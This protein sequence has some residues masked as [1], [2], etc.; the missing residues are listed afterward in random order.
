M[1]LSDRQ[2]K[3][4]YANGTIVIDPFEEKFVQPAS[5]DLRVGNQGITTSDKKVVDL[6]INK[7]IVIKPADFAVIMSLEK[8]KLDNRHIGRIGLRSKWARDG[9][10]ATMGP[11][12]DPG[13]EGRL[14]IGLTNLSPKAMPISYKERLITIEFHQLEEPAENVYSGPYAGK[15]ELGQEDL[16]R[17]IDTN[18][19]VISEVL[20]DI[21]SLTRNVSHLTNEYTELSKSM[22]NLATKMGYVMWTVPIGFGLLGIILAIVNK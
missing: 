13:F 20:E 18:G 9:L 6:Q 12:V 7:Y 1:I 3:E 5:Y 14:V 22:S 17:I 4:A 16:N 8:L 10:I 15:E 21:R 11:Q 2:I 19:M